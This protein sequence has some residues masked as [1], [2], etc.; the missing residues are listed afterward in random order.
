MIINRLILKITIVV[1]LLISCNGKEFHK[2]VLIGIWSIDS[3]YY[4]NKFN[5]GLFFSNGLIFEK[6]KIIFPNSI[7]L[8]SFL[9]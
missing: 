2:D 5:N 4:N 1:L 9:I 6:D 3:V 7:T 8:S